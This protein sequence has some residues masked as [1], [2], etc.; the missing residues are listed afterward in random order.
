MYTNNY[1]H[2]HEWSIFGTFYRDSVLMKVCI[3]NNH[4]KHKNR[5]KSAREEYISGHLSE[6]IKDNPKRFWFYVKRL[7]QENPG[8][9]D[10]EVDGKVI[11][12]GGLKSEILNSQF[13]SV[14]TTEDLENI[15]EMGSNPTSGLGPLIISEQGVLKQLSSLNPNKACDPDQIPPWFL[16]TF[17]AD[18]APILTDIFQ[19]SIDNGSAPHRW[20]EANECAVFKKGEK[21]DPANYRPISLTCV[22]S[23]ILE[24]IVY[25]FIMKHL[26][27]H[28]ILTDCQQGLREKRSTEM[29][30]ILTL[31]D[32]AKAIQSSPIHAVVLDFAKAFDK[33]PHRRLLRKLQ[34]YNGIQ[35]SLLN[36]F[37]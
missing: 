28:N 37:T 1:E 27:N 24:H 36:W 17:A 5:L 8:I 32:M 29:Q 3:F 20:K 13:S 22:A 30:V 7:K 33:V 2:L 25:S 34:H 31:Q 21:S 16:Q 35:G 18:I 23:K 6:A 14:F 19:D 12:D 26:N 10:F 15:P 4:I 9:A 11:S